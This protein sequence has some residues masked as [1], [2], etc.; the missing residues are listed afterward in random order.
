[1]HA[2]I[3]GPVVGIQREP[4]RL[5]FRP[6][7]PFGEP[8]EERAARLRRARLGL[9]ELARRICDQAG[10]EAPKERRSD[11]GANTVQ[12]LWKAP[13]SHARVWRD[14]L[15]SKFQPVGRRG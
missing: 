9:D 14:G 3:E 12:T 5:R 8:I 13:S 11:C 1:M 15:I 6:P 4:Q 7:E 10:L 2:P